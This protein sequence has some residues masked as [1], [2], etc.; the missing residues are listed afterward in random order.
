MD[1]MQYL[2]V[3]LLFL[4]AIGGAIL[5]L[6]FTKL[7]GGKKVKERVLREFDGEALDNAV[8]FKFEGY[9]VLA[10]FR[11]ELKFSILHNLGDEKVRNIRVPK[12]MK[13]TPL[14]L[15]VRVKNT[16]NMREKLIEAV[17]FL[18]SQ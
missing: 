2:A 11:S 9:E 16:K 18:K 8:S 5:Y 17:N 6:I 12:N 1:S 4:A 13:L 7:S 14:Y 3:I 10:T 15:I